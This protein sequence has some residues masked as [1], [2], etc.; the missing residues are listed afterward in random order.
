MM[1]N[2]W[3]EMDGRLKNNIF[4]ETLCKLKFNRKHI[5]GGSWNGLKQAK[6]DHFL[7]VVLECCGSNIY[8]KS[9][10]WTM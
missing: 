2:G 7:F 1:I 8:D 6:P 5:T 4:I 9:I 10:L 3:M